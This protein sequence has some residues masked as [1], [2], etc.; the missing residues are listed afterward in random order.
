MRKRSASLRACEAA[1][2]GGI[3]STSI[4]NAL[5]VR[6][7]TIKCQGHSIP[8]VAW[9]APLHDRQFPVPSTQEAQ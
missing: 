5:I 2:A 1:A 3:G 9:C 4:H 7:R 8:F 6:H